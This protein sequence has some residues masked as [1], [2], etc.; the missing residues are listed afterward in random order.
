MPLHVASKSKDS[1]IGTPPAVYTTLPSLL[2]SIAGNTMIELPTATVRPARR[3]VRRNRNRKRNRNENRKRNVNGNINRN[4]NGNKR[5]NR[6]WSRNRNRNR[7]RRGQ[8]RENINLS[9]RL[10]LFGKR[11]VA[12]RADIYITT[13]QFD[14]IRCLQ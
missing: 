9:Y 6:N 10:S 14:A 5:R 4:R 13:L 12:V 1:F 2:D 7:N 3:K 11:E 8:E